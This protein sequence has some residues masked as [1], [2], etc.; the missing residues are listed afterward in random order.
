MGRHRATIV[1]KR[2]GAKQYRY[3]VLDMYNA[4]LAR[5]NGTSYKQTRN[6]A[7]EARRK[8]EAAGKAL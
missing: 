7:N 1:M 5:G 8:A 3:F 6:M 2:T 4:E